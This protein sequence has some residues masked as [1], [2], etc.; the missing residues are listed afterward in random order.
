MEKNMKKNACMCIYICICIVQSL[1]RV[2]LCNPMHSSTPGFPVLYNLL[3]FAQTR[4]H[5]VDDAIQPVPFSSL[6]HSFPASGSFPMSQFFASGGQS[7]GVLASSALP[8]NIQDWFPWGLAGLISLLSKELSRV[9]SSPTIWKH[10]FF[11][12]LPSLWSKSHIHTWLL[13]KP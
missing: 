10:Q 7:V 13:E 3:Q 6:L 2:Q 12:T 8:V 9:F 1:S 5:W 11:S 4:V